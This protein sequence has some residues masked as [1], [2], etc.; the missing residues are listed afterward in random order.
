MNATL[1]GHDVF[2]L[3]PTGASTASR[4][5]LPGRQ[6]GAALVASDLPGDSSA[7]VSHLH[8][9]AP[10]GG[11]KSLCYQLPALLSRGVTIVVSPLV[12]LIQD[13]V[14][15]RTACPQ[16]SAGHSRL[17][18]RKSILT[19]SYCDLS[20]RRGCL[21]HHRPAGAPPDGAGHRGRL[22]GRQH[23]LG[24]AGAGVQQPV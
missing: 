24:A 22:R 9:P 21:P 14:C 6:P 18:L 11:G 23:D 10:A 13:Q 3:M 16:R 1:S 17:L 12:S 19:M 5:L 2:V 7:I 20:R 8:P 4:A 15:A